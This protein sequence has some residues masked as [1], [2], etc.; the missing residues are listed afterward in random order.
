M[1]VSIID[2]LSRSLWAAALVTATMFV[3]HEAAAAKP[4]G[5]RPGGVGGAKPNLAHAGFQGSVSRG[6]LTK[7]SPLKSPNLGSAQRTASPIGNPAKFPLNPGLGNIKPAKFPG[8]F[9]GTPINPGSFPTF[10]PINPGGGVPTTPPFNPGSGIPTTP[11]INPNPPVC[12]PHPKCHPFFWY[13]AGYRFGL[14][15][16]RGGCYIPPVCTVPVVQTVTAGGSTIIVQDNDTILAGAQ[17]IDLVAELPR[18]VVGSTVSLSGNNLG[19]EAGQVLLEING[20]ALPCRIDVWAAD[21]ATTTLP[22]FGL[23]SETKGKMHVI[24]ADGSVARSLDVVVVP[25]VE[26]A[27]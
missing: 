8:G 27:K 21:K 14:Y 17:Q 7:V 9:T 11:P 3:T 12:S 1:S 4:G 10:P 23:G 2:V 26:A 5:A 20:L 13:G 6:N 22:S 25:A 24:R 15:G 19:A 18:V 16:W